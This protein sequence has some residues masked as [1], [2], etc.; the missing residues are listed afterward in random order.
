MAGHTGLSLGLHPDGLSPI[1]SLIQGCLALVIGTAFFVSGMLGLADGYERATG[2]LRELLP[3]KQPPAESLPLCDPAALAASA[4]IFWR[5]YQ[6]AAIGVLVFLGGLL[7]LTLT[8]SGSSMAF[9]TV[10]IGVGIAVLAGATV[11]LSIGGLRR[12]RRCHVDV[13]R[14]ASILAAQPDRVAERPPVRPRR[15][16]AYSLFKGSG[17]IG[18]DVERRRSVARAA[19]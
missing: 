11:A 18:R 14:S 9:Y 2:G 19:P 1:G 13:A 17:G 10:G 5:G 15:L 16:P 7:A 6:R 12:M 8:L 3:L 4:A